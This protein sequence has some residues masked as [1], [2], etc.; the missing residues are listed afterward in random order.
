VSVLFYYTQKALLRQTSLKLNEKTELTR[1][2]APSL[3]HKVSH[4]HP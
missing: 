1:W 3:C 2:H 4:S